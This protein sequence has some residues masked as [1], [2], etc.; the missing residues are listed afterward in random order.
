MP[1]RDQLIRTLD[2]VNLSHAIWGESGPAAVERINHHL[3]VSLDGALKN[4]VEDVGNLRVDPLALTVAGDQSG[5]IGTV[6]STK[7]LRK[8]NP[9]IQNNLVHVMEHAGE[10]YLYNLSTFAV[11]AYDAHHVAVGQETMRWA[12]LD[13]LIDWMI[14]EAEAFQRGGEFNMD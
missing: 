8:S 7:E 11:C 5:V 4:F 13:E 10:I 14:K 12:S 6:V 1:Y 3:N 9:G 2:C